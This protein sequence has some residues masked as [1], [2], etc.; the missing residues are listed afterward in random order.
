MLG[1]AMLGYG[2]VGYAILGWLGYAR[3]CYAM[4]SECPSVVPDGPKLAGQCEA[5]MRCHFGTA[6]DCLPTG[7][8][9]RRGPI[10]GYTPAARGGYGVGAPTALL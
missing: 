9:D 5:H 3:L 8:P 4:P 10:S 2:I 1:H 6:P 7:E